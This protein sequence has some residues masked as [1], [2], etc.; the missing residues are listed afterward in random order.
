M[1][2][3]PSLFEGID[4]NFPLVLGCFESLHSRIEV[5]FGLLQTSAK[6]EQNYEE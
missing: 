3:L 5:P 4:G 1:A 6:Y 2:V